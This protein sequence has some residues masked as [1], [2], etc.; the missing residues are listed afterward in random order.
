[1][2][3][4]PDISKIKKILLIQYKPFGDI[5][6]NT[7]YMKALREKFPNAQIDYLIQRPYVTVLENNPYLD[8]LVIMEKKKKKSLDYFK[9]KLRIISRIRAENYDVV[10]DQLRNAGSAQITLFSGAKYKIGW[11][12]N[13]GFKSF[14]WIYNYSE[15]RNNLVYASRAKFALLKPLGIEEIP[16]NTFYHVKPESREMV[17]I[18]LNDSGLI[19]KK[20]VLFSPVTPIPA[21][22]WDLERFAKVADMI[23]KDSDFEIVLMWGPGEKEQVEYMASKMETK[24][25]IAPKTSFNEAAALLEKSK[26]YIGNDGGINHLAVAVNTPTITVFGPKTNPKK[27]TAWHLN[28]H[29]YLRDYDFK[30]KGEHT[31]NITPEMVFEKFLELKSII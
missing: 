4:I 2:S 24:P 26:I 29:K 25:V 31:F 1:M 14:N 22:Q 12:F 9:E 20:I 23:K 8:N 21:K 16:H 5:L 30:E 27:W 3:T 15:E 17:N 6:L 13:K 7:G 10:I 28:I 18:W 11:R 19:D